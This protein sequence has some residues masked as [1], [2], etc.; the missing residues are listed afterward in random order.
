[1]IVVIC[2]RGGRRS[3]FPFSGG[4]LFTALLNTS[5]ISLLGDF[6][7]DLGRMVWIG[8]ECGLYFPEIDIIF[9]VFNEGF[10]T[11]TS[12]LR[13]KALSHEN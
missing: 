7:F 5:G 13:M 12:T 10:C 3:K 8:N 1:M 2:S 4:L 11:M 6:L 9:R